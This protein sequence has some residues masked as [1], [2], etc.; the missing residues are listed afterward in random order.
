MKI[1]LLSARFPPQR[2]GVGDYTCFLADALARVG[3]DVDVL[4]GAGE[5]DESLYALPLNVR[6]HRVVDSWATKRLPDVITHLRKLDPQVLLIQYAPHA[7][8]HRGITFAVNLLPALVRSS[9]GT[10]VVTN[11]HELYIPFDHSLKRNAGA[12]WQ[13][14]AVGLLA[15]GSHTLSV[16]VSAWERRLKRIGFRKHIQ[17]VPVGSNIP[18][19][20]ISEA[21]RTRVRK[22]L[23]GE[24][25][26]LLVA[27]FGA[28]HDRDIPAALYA[29][30]QLKRER[31]AKLVWI[32]GGSAGE[33][34][35]L[36]IEEA[37]RVNGL[38]EDDVNWTGQLP[39]SEVSRLLS[40]CDLMML[41]FVDGV[42]TR[43]TSA[44]TALQHG[45]PLLTTR[46][47]RQEPWF[48]HGKNVYLVPAGD[49]N[50]LADGLMDL[51]RNTELR[52]GLGE[53]ARTLF[54]THFAW[55]VIAEQVAGLATAALGG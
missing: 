24:S 22:Q 48:V 7:F 50:G 55:D 45:L 9:I 8:D 12:L 17:V 14:A 43:R 28:R 6:V 41:P 54:N 4:T 53:G 15:T 26:G 31:P 49:G 20:T 47:T 19:A 3:H 36:S 10:R 5:L 52:A 44:V 39:H 51:G 11:F 35:R 2:C 16:T 37:M 32:G 25:E 40:V 34:E 38:E 29:L 23:L 27:G 33:R 46:G 42:S 1:C 13:R 18:L 30:Q 21:H